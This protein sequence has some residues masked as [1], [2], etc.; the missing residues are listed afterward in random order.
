MATGPFS[1]AARRAITVAHGETMRLGRDCVS[2]DLIVLG[3]INADPDG[4]V[5][6]A[7]EIEGVDSAAL[8]RAIAGP[9][10]PRAHSDPAPGGPHVPFCPETRDAMSLV[11]PER[12]K[13]QHDQVDTAILLLALIAG[14]ESRVT[15]L[16]APYGVHPR[17]VRTR[18]IRLVANSRG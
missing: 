18:I 6:Q 13:L 9:D 17:Q 2:V 3:I 10:G 16:L 15:E 11:M 1:D 4:I 12:D 5:A 8:L 7:L 14:A